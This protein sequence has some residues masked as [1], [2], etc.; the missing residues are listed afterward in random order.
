MPSVLAYNTEHRKYIEFLLCES[1]SEQIEEVSIRHPF[2]PFE[3]AVCAVKGG[4][5]NIARNI[6]NNQLGGRTDHNKRRKTHN[7]VQGEQANE[8]RKKNG[9]K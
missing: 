8:R 5:H 9:K 1:T 7:V 3:A 6:D 2:E 4:R